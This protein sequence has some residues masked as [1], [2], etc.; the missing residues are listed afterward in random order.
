MLID[1][2]WWHVGAI[3]VQEKQ[4]KYVKAEQYI[5]VMTEAKTYLEDFLPKAAIGMQMQWDGRALVWAIVGDVSHWPLFHKCVKRELESY[6]K[7]M[8]VRRCEMVT[9][10]GF[11]QAARWAEMLGFK[12]ESIMKKYLPHGADAIMWVRV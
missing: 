7:K 11:E 4:K 2:E 5:G 6:I 9:E 12:Q 3:N 8:N 10:L 1:F